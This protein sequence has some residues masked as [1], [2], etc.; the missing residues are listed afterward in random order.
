MK[1]AEGVRH[2]VENLLSSCIS[3]R[4]PSREV[5]VWLERIGADL[6]GKLEAVGLV[7]PLEPLQ[8]DQTSLDE[9]V[10]N[11]IERVGSNRK[12]GTVAVWKQVQAELTKFMPKGILLADVTKGH[13]KQFHESLKKRGLASLTVVKHVRISKQML[14]DAVEWEKILTNPFAKI[15]LSASI[16]KNNVEVTRDRID[17]LMRHCDPTWQLI[18]A[19]SRFGG[20]R[21]PSETL[22]LR[23]TNIDW[24]HSRMNVP[25]PKVEHH[26][27][28]GIRSVPIFPELMPY[29]QAAWDLA[30]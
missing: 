7:E 20:I 4:E 10:A 18:I 17:E 24:E 2:R 13:A 26:E 19:L 3:N 25:E 5:A 21:C 1:I 9:H 29:L 16:P 8:I 28:R 23:W 12:P 22:S 14:E 15:K 6:L 30:S 11:F 27:G